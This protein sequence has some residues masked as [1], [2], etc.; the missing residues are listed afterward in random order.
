MTMRPE[1]TASVARSVLE[2]GLLTRAKSLRLYYIGPMFRAERPVRAANA[3]S[4]R[5]GPRSS[6]RIMPRL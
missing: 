6:T 1:M 3:S 4:T 5:S 2:K